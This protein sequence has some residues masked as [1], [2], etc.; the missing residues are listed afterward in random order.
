MDEQI[1]ANPGST[2]GEAV[3]AV[4]EKGVNQ[5]LQP[6]AE[7]HGCVYVSVGPTNLRTGHPT[8]LLMK[9]AAG[10]TFHINSVIA[11]NRIQ[12]LV[13]IES[14]FIHQPEH[15]RDDAN[16]ICTAHSSLR[17]TFPTIRKSIIVLAGN[18]RAGSKTIM[19]SCDI[20][21]FEIGFPKVVATLEQ[22]GVDFR[23]EEKERYRAYAAW[24][25][26]K[27]LDDAQYQE[28]A[29]K[30]L[31]DIESELYASLHSALDSKKPLIR[32]I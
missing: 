14:K 4:L 15:S 30:L 20:S 23:W 24:Q 32:N 31:S 5:L 1:V 17:R 25:R 19:E 2:L 26:W 16:L 3:G 9:D 8:R 29:H 13:L 21:L 28:I 10:N 27:Q 18:W 11:N 7:E 12:P 6:V 22:Y